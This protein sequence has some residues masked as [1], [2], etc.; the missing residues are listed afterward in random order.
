[1]TAMR[2][3]K[4]T[5]FMRNRFFKMGAG[6]VTLAA[7]VFSTAA[8]PQPPYGSTL[9]ALNGANPNGIWNLYELDDGVFDSGVISNGWILALTTANPVGAAA[10]NLISMT[11]TAGTV[12]T[13]G[14]GVYILTV[15]NYGP[16]TS[17]N[18]VVVDTLPLGVLLVSTNV[19]PGTTVSRSG[20]QL[21]WNIGTLTNN[22]DVQLMLT[23]QFNS[24]G[25]FDNIAIVSAST[26][27]PNP[28]DDFAQATINAGTIPPPQLTNTI[29]NINGTFQLTVNG[30]PGQEY[31]VQ[32]STNLIN[33]VS[34]YT[35]PP[36]FVSPFTFID[37][38]ASNYPDRFYRV[39][40]GP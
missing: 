28:D 15:T 9:N 40:P 18:V 25:S 4:P 10:D 1:M 22:A 29:V 32:A 8:A 24:S 23:N 16:S 31:I 20:N 33:W 2:N 7:L 14:I 3:L 37:S 26:P 12:P 6:L 11:A 30:Q 5:A 39:V 13:N 34:V 21:T 19:T 35:N 38:G 27:D 36:P 17:S